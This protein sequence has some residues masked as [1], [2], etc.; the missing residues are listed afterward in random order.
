FEKMTDNQMTDFKDKITKFSN[1]LKEA[2][3]EID[4]YAQYKKLNKIF[5]DDF[6][7][8]EEKNT[9]KN[10]VN[11]IPSSSSSGWEIY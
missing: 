6:E 11:Y 1:D 8:P 7:I 4:E 9:A 5:G 3:N 10:Q 2:R